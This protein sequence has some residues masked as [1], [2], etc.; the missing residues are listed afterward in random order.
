M[1][2]MHLYLHQR[3]GTC[4]LEKCRCRQERRAI[5]YPCINWTASGARTWDELAEKMKAFYAGSGK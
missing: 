5:G 2:D 1:D 3:Y 4:S